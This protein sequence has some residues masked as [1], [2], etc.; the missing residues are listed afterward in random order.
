M[1]NQQP[2]PNAPDAIPITVDF[3]FRSL[4]AYL[5]QHDPILLILYG[6]MY[7]GFV[8]I[9]LPRLAYAISSMVLFVA[10]KQSVDGYM[11]LT[12]NYSVDQQL[13]LITTIVAFM[14]L[15]M[16]CTAKTFNLF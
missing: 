13:S 4:N 14:A 1:E 6:M 10:V 3:L 11:R 8:F 9:I 15:Q 12:G 7:A 5:A 2:Q 16:Y